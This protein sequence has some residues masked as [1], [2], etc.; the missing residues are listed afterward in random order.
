MLAHIRASELQASLKELYDLWAE[1]RGADQTGPVVVDLKQWFGDMT[2]NAFV[3]MVGG[4]TR[5]VKA[6]GGGGGGGGEERKVVRD[7][8]YYFGVFVL[9][10]AIPSLAWLDLQGHE[11]NMKRIAKELDDVV[12]QW[13]QEHKERRKKT[14]RVDEDFMDAMLTILEGEDFPGV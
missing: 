2:L 11:R 13:L 9:S 3:Q 12:G 7:L 6:N 14:S 5:A 1:A 10:D 8:M 4:R